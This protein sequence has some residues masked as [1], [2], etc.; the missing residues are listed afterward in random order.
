MSAHGEGQTRNAVPEM[1]MEPFM[2]E[3]APQPAS[4]IYIDA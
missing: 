1:D 3:K 4:L 2:A